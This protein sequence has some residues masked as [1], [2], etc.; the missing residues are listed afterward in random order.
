MTEHFQY[1]P[2][3]YRLLQFLLG[4][5]EWF[6]EDGATIRENLLRVRDLGIDGLVISVNQKQ[7]LRSEKAWDAFQLGV[8]ISKELGLRLWIYDEEGYPSGAA[9]GLVLEKDPSLEATGLI[10]H[11]DRSE[12]SRYEVVPLYDGTHATENFYQKRRYINILDPKATATFLEVTHE[13]YTRHLGDLSQWFEAVF[14][15]EPSLITAYIPTGKT[16]PLTLPWSR[17]LPQVFFERKGYDLTP[18]LESLYRDTGED[19]RRI[20]CDFY[21]VISELCAENYFGQI[22]KWCTEPRH[23]IKWTPSR[24]GNPRV[25]NLFRGKSLCL[26]SEIRHSRHRH[27]PLQSRANHAREVFHRPKASEFRR[28]TYG[29]TRGHVRDQ[30]LL[31]IHG[32]ASRN[33]RADDGHSKYSVCTRCH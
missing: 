11:P 27:D 1:P 12:G 25:A 24:R 20:R 7:Y 18:H 17:S 26:L 9:G 30:R 31:R 16:Y 22:Q 19:Y 5:E 32:E 8:R 13:A 10:Y 15:D 2:P 14:T 6:G 29:K 23:R 4:Y 28:S 33:S 3:K 21:E